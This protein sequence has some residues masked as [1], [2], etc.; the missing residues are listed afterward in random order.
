LE[1]FYSFPFPEHSPFREQSAE[2]TRLV[3]NYNI[4][5]RTLLNH[6]HLHPSLRRKEDHK[7]QYLSGFSEL[8]AQIKTEVHFSLFTLRSTLTLSTSSSTFIN[9]STNHNIWFPIVFYVYYLIS[10]SYIRINYTFLVIFIP[11]SLSPHTFDCS[12]HI[13]K[14]YRLRFFTFLFPKLKFSNVKISFIMFCISLKIVSSETLFVE[15]CFQ[16]LAGCSKTSL[17]YKF[18]TDHPVVY[19]QICIIHEGF[20]LPFYYTVPLF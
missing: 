6:H 5:H 1:E 16:N 20:I 4:H 19:Y 11:S 9:Y 13:F 3:N 17:C 15:E 8:Q 10:L 2:L 14:K 7:S 18:K 12:L